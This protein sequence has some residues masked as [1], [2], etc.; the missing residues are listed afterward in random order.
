[1]LRPDGS[2]YIREEGTVN[3]NSQYIESTFF[4]LR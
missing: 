1:L 3:E 4:K 2:L